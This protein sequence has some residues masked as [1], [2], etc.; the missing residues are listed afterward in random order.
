[1]NTYVNNVMISNLA[2]GAI[3]T[4]KPADTATNTAVA[5]AGK[6]IFMNCEDGTVGATITGKVVK[7]GLIQNK[8]QPKVDYST[9]AT[10]YEPVIKW[11]NE[12]KKADVRGLHK[13]EYK[14]ETE[15]T[16]EIK[17]KNM[18]TQMKTKLGMAGKRIIVR[19]TF[20]DMPHR[21]RKWTE[22][23]EYVTKDGD[24]EKN[25]PEKLA[26]LINKQYKRARVIASAVVEGSGTDKTTLKIE[27]LP[28]DDDDSVM[29]ISPA[30]KVRFV[31][32]VYFTDPSASGFA[33][34]NKYFIDGV[35]IKKTEG[36]DGECNWKHVRDREYWAQGYE[37]IL[38]RGEGTWPI[39]RPD[40]EVQKGAKYDSLTL[41]FENSYRAADDI[42]RKTS[43]CLEIY[44]LKGQLGL[45][46][47]ELNKLV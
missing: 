42:V 12:I 9:G 34:K 25:L 1:M 43:Q 31:A 16:V 2:T 38:N 39:I 30:N 17:F 37:G 26:N 22:S 35:V 14:D 28:Y 6:F 10:T 23:Y 41:E 29:S 47:T 4:A 20:K 5:D 24:N 27:A 40:M 15:D 11:S 18:S 46:E 36:H 45:V 3:A 7:V 13:K 32:N 44:G 8:R 19:L 33:S 21:F